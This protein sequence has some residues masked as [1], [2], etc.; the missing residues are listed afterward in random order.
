MQLITCIEVVLAFITADNSFH[1]AVV[2]AAAAAAASADAFV[3][4]T[5]VFTVTLASTFAFWTK[6]RFVLY[7]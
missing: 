4:N 5:T 7:E 6:K 2:A 1:R 3:A